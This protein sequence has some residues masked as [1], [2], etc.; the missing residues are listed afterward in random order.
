M[1]CP[2][3]KGAMVVV[4]HKRIELDYCTKCFGVWFDAGE[5]ELL[6]ERL[7]LGEAASGVGGIMALSERKVS[8]KARPCPICARKMRKVAAGSTPE[9]LVD[10][11]SRGHGVWF[12]GGEIGQ[13]LGQ[14]AGAGSGAA[15]KQVK[16][17]AFLGEV[18]QARE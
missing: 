10:I 6:A 14:L 1:N 3:C 16:V 9:V 4:E 12:D 18:F 5:L 7:G 8:E 15:D 11:C 2:A 13:V 17:I